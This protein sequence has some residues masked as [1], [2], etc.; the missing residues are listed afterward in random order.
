MLYN[1]NVQ[2]MF[3]WSYVLGHNIKAAKSVME[4]VVHFMVDSKQKETGGGKTFKSIPTITCF[5]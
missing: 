1:K 3:A 4:E 5:V 2:F